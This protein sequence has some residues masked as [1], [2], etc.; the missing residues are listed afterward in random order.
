[1]ANGGATTAGKGWQVWI[2]LI[3]SLL[4]IG[5]YLFYMLAAAF[6]FRH[7][8][9]AD[10][11]IYPLFKEGDIR[12]HEHWFFMKSHYLHVVVYFLA[13]AMYL[14]AIQTGQMRCAL[15]TLSV[16][17]VLIILFSAFS[18]FWIIGAC[19]D[20][21]MT[22]G[23]EFGQ[24]I[25]EAVRANDTAL[26]PDT[27]P[28]HEISDPYR[29]HLWTVPFLLLLSA[30]LPCLAC[31]F[32]QDTLQEEDAEMENEKREKR[33]Q[34]I[35]TAVRRKKNAPKEKENG[36]MLTENPSFMDA[37]YGIENKRKKT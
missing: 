19:T 22:D 33:A 31:V 27:E 11:N 15:I 20:S 26:K 37:L 5:L 24:C 2:M 17:A 34:R 13:P 7:P 10:E 8:R 3:L 14:V 28:Q 35:E 9:D 16:S 25:Y 23:N 1:M 12:F 6:D 18:Y 36:P 29:I 21:S 4:G 32:F 30:V